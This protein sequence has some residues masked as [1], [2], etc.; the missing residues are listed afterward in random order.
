MGPA[1]ALRAAQDSK[2][3]FKEPWGQHQPEPGAH[4]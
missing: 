2:P 3:A 4:A 1:P